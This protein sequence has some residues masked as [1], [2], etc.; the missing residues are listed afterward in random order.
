[1]QRTSNPWFA[2]T[3]VLAITMVSAACAEERV[4]GLSS[5]KAGLAETFDWNSGTAGAA[6]ET[7]DICKDG[8]TGAYNFTLTATGGVTPLGTAF[9]LAAGQCATVWIGDSGDRHMVSVTEGDPPAGVSFDRI[10]VSNEPQD[11]PSTIDNATRT[12][13]YEVNFFHGGRATF[14]NVAKPQPIGTEGCTPGYWKNHPESWT[15]AGTTSFD[16]FFGVDFFNPDIDLATAIGLNGAGANALARH[17]TAAALNIDSAGVDY[18]IT[19]QEL[20]KAVQDAYNGVRGVE[21]VKDML[22]NYNNLG[23]PL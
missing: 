14:Y 15:I 16:A 11:G 12:V 7:I 20:K 22:D 8:P 2:R 5:G 1:M 18:P 4:T 13:T 19:M 9:T 23:C 10:E 17:A 3:L 21:E 6:A